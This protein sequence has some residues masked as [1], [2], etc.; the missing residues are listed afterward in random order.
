MTDKIQGLG[1]QVYSIEL[2]DLFAM[3]IAAGDLAAQSPDRAEGWYRLADA[4]ILQRELTRKQPQEAATH[5][6][7]TA[8][9]R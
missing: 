9:A 1:P 2:R 8:P 5:T 3:A 4:M 6:E 7:E